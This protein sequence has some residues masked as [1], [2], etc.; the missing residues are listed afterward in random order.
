M[1]LIF[2]GVCALIGGLAA[3]ALALWTMMWLD[4]PLAINCLSLR[5][6]ERKRKRVFWSVGAAA[7]AV[8]F[9]LLLTR[10]AWAIVDVDVDA[11]EAAKEVGSWG[12]GH[13]AIVMAG[14]VVIT[15]IWKFGP[16]QWRSIGISWSLTGGIKMP[17]RQ[18]PRTAAG[19]PGT[20]TPRDVL[21]QQ[22]T[23]IRDR[24]ADLVSKQDLRELK[25]DLMKALNDHDKSNAEDFKDLSGRMK[26]LEDQRPGDSNR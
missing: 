22:I 11:A 2:A 12:Y 7:S 1:T 17:P 10:G 21:W 15:L 16:K 20:A 13:V 6:R 5:E 3:A 26:A 9:L 19:S 4:W 14:L 8:I 18:R 24:M 23:E 25:A